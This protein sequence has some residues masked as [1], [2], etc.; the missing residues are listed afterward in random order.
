M[1]TEKNQVFNLETQ[2][3]NQNGNNSKFT[4]TNELLPNTPFRIVGNTEH[5]YALTIGE[6]RL[7][8]PTKTALESIQK[9]DTHQWEIIANMIL[10]LIEKWHKMTP[11]DPRD[12]KT[13]I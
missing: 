4:T 11:L 2:K 10:V 6:Y 9:L 3:N 13:S 1:E 12:Q 8:Q 7:T 5:G